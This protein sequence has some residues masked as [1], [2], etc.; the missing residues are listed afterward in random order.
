[1]IGM[2]MQRIREYYNVPAR[3]GM[4]ITMDGQPG[5]IVASDPTSMHLRVRFDGQRHSLRVHPTW[6][7]EY[8][9]E[10]A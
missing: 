9:T 10:E 1:M 7:V 5:V 8:Q 3:R 2:S 6:R 4:R